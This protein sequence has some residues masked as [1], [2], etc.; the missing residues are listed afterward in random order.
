MAKTNHTHYSRDKTN[1]MI[2]F[3][4]DSMLKQKQ[5]FRQLGEAKCASLKHRYIK[6]LKTN[7]NLLELKKNFNFEGIQMEIAPDNRNLK[8][9]LFL[10]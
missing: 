2:L 10:L 4:D 8:S 6:K 7:L 9:D 5:H 3:S 1:E